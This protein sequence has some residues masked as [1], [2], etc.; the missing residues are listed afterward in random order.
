MKRI[1]WTRTILIFL[2]GLNAMTACQA[3][4]LDGYWQTDGYGYLLH[5][6]GARYKVYEVSRQSCMRVADGHLSGNLT[7]ALSMEDWGMEVSLDSGGL[8]LRN[9]MTQYIFARRVETPPAPCRD[10][11]TPKT[12][13]PI[14][15]F[16]VFWANFDE[17]YAFFDLYGVDWQ[18]VYN[19]YRPRVT[20]STSPDA[21]YAIFTEMLAPLK[22]DHIVLVNNKKRVFSPVNLSSEYRKFFPRGGTVT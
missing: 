16:E 3:A 6:S 5:F 1:T 13:D 12:D 11:G 18:Q 20:A 14:T 10:G 17:H 4:G 9:N 8:A 22:D 7:S 19:K 2:L 15:N 21:L